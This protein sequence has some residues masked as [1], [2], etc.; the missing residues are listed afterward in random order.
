MFWNDHSKLKGQHAFLG[1]SNYHWIN[2]DDETLAQRYYSQYAT[3]VGTVLHEFAENC[4]NSR[5]K[6]TKHDKHAVEMALYLGGIPKGAVDIDKALLNLLPFVNDAIG[7]HMSS[8]VILYYSKNCYGTTDA[9]GYQEKEHILR[10]HDYKSGVTPA[11]FEQ[12]LIYAALFY[13]EYHKKPSEHIT[14]L[15]IYQSNE[16][17]V[18]TPDPMEVEKY[19]DM[20][21][22]RD[23]YITNNIL[24]GA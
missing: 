19:M 4:I 2:W 11:H 13:L 20:I 1:A 18:Y 8:E 23:M 12:L 14:E 3:S 7:Y 6:L 10:I 16:V 15:R 9:I 22:S 17:S 5:M 21:R 24:K